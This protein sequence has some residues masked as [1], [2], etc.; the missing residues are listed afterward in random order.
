MLV[1]P[2]STRTPVVFDAPIVFCTVFALCSV[3]CAEW[4]AVA[5]LWLDARRGGDC[6][7]DSARK[8]PLFF[9]ARGGPSGTAAA[10]PEADAIA[11]AWSTETPATDA[12]NS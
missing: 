1:A 7:T 5:G 8:S 3:F 2:G 9:L 6:S 4:A 12:S 10:L 11:L